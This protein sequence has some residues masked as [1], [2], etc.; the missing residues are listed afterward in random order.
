M[1]PGY[2]APIEAREVQRVCLCKQEVL[3]RRQCCCKIAS[4][5]GT[6]LR[7]TPLRLPFGILKKYLPTWN[8]EGPSFN[9]WPATC[10]RS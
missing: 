1:E 6:L 2:E 10:A 7:A 8:Y 5:I 9:E 4:Q 3:H